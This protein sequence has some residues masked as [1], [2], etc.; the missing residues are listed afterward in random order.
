M[1]QMT[2]R[3][4]AVSI[5]GGVLFGVMDVL[6]NGNPLAQVL[7]EAYRPIAK[8]S[9]DVVSGIGIDLFYG[10]VM[11]GMFLLLYRSLLGQVGLT[12]GISYALIVWFFRVVMQV[13]SQWMMFNISPVTLIY[14]LV[15]GLAEMLAIGVFYG[16]TLRPTIRK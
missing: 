14:V 3:I 13:A 6:I 11:T 1:R 10:F 12:K 9:V 4:V 5:I 7:Y 8:T 2:T 15:T 16:L